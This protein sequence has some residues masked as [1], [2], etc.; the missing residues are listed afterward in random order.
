MCLGLQID[1]FFSFSLCDDNNPRVKLQNDYW[2]LRSRAHP[3]RNE[4]HERTKR[5][6]PT[7]SLRLVHPLF[8]LVTNVAHLIILM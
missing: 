6:R 7:T 1:Q 4:T 5:R 8:S 3:Y 2:R